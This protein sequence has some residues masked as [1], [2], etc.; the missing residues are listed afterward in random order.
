MARYRATVFTPL[1]PDEAFAYLSDFATTE[2]WDPGVVRA[3]RITRGAPALGS[4]FRVTSAVLGRE[5]SLT[6]RI[7]AH[8]PPRAVTLIGG[9]CSII[10]EDTIT[11][12]PTGE[13][14]T[15]I[16]YD[17]DLR[18]RGP[19]R[20]ADPLLALVLQRIGDR[21]R[22]GLARRLGAEGRHVLH[23]LSGRA[24]D[25]RSYQLPAELPA[26]RNLLLV[27]FR[28]E[29]QELIDG[30]LPWAL[31]REGGEAGI[32]VFEVPVLSARYSPARWFIDGGMTRG[33]P[34]A[35]A[36]ARTITVYTD[37]AAVVDNLGLAGTNTI[38][39]VVVE[40]SGRIIALETGAFTRTKARRLT[41][42]LEP[43]AVAAHA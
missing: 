27:A 31:K 18:L 12:Q 40:P 23:P 36:R 29:Q 37:V 41:E 35:A 16:S 15:S 26:A 3:E 17:A 9:N 7:V 10:S 39:A 8:D 1:A 22:A 6:Y 19:L 14:G 13:G 42:A 20:A 30:W 38:A 2:E 11:F 25:G 32:A 24:L 28:R 4:E 33:I 34:D 5:T 43:T 21:A